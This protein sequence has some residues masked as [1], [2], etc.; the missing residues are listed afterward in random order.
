M[1]ILIWGFSTFYGANHQAAVSFSE[2]WHASLSRVDFAFADLTP[3]SVLVGL[4]PR[5]FAS[6]VHAG[7]FVGWVHHVVALV[8]ERRVDQGRLM[9]STFRLRDHLGVHPVATTMLDDMIRHMARR[10]VTA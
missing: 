8:A 9:A 7:L 4:S 6:R 3:D 1:R 10:P 2:P 5:D